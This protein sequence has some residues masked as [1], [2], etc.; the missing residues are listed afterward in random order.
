MIR[1]I[2]KWKRIPLGIVYQIRESGIEIM[3]DYDQSNTKMKKNSI[4]HSVSKN[5]KWNL[6]KSN[7]SKSWKVAW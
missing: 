6:K 3:I 4:R 5:K 2:V 7:S 1:V